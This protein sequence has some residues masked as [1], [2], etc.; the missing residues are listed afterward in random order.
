MIISCTILLGVSN[1]LDEVG[2][3]IKKNYFQC[4]FRNSCRL[5]DN[6]E[7]YGTVKQ[8]KDGN[9]IRRMPFTCP[10][11]RLQTQTHTKNM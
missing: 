8:A 10:M 4:F 2:D 7:K 6:M 11:I 1:G 5:C 3:E 9:I